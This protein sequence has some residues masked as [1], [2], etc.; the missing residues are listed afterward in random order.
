[1]DT[2]QVCESERRWYIPSLWRVITAQYSSSSRTRT[3]KVYVDS[4]QVC[5]HTVSNMGI[6]FSNLWLTVNQLELT[7]TTFSFSESQFCSSNSQWFGV[8]Y[9]K[10]VNNQSYGDKS[11]KS[12]N[13]QS[14]RGNFS[15]KICEQAWGINYVAILLFKDLGCIH[16]GV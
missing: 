1:M 11:L 10:F 7:A 9:L 6:C 12:V 5:E 14:H 16:A 4:T 2:S 3:V 13:S 8:I 15:K